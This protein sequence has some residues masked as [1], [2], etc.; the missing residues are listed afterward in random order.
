[1]KRIVSLLIALVM[2]I[3]M[4][5]CGAAEPTPTEMTMTTTGDVVTTPKEDP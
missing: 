2:L 4:T 5:A 3:S 1:M